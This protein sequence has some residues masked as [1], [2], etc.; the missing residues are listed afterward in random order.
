MPDKKAVTINASFYPAADRLVSVPRGKKPYAGVATI[1]YGASVSTFRID[2]WL[3]KRHPG[4]KVK[5]RSVPE[6]ELH[7]KG[8]LISGPKVGDIELSLTTA[9]ED[10]FLHYRDAF[11]PDLKMAV[12][13]QTK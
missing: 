9:N 12:R 13:V 1:R 10:G 11:N 3:S 5:S 6:V 2:G 4:P 7:A 8:R